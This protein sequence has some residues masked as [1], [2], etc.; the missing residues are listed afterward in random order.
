[1]KP[2]SK[3][4]NSSS[5]DRALVAHISKNERALVKRGSKNENSD[6]TDNFAGALLAVELG[7]VSSAA[8]TATV[9][10]AIAPTINH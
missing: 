8:T 10:A 9:L 3:N 1:M 4:S 6:S 5:G 7:Y 2:A